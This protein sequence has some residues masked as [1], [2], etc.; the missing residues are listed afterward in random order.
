MFSRQPQYTVP[1]Y[2]EKLSS[3]TPSCDI[4]R[5]AI[6]KNVYFYTNRY[7]VKKMWY[8]RIFKGLAAKIVY[9]KF[10]KCRIVD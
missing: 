8:S 1:E 2:I 6:Y 9:L 10:R 5:A 7:Y 3:G 4:N